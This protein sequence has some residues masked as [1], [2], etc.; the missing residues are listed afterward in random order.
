MNFVTLLDGPAALIVFG[1]TTLATLLRCGW[2]DC[3]AAVRAVG[4][5]GDTR[6]DA[7]G[8]RAEL[9]VQIQEI[10]R[11]GIL[12]AAPH[13]FGDREFDEVTGALIRRRSVGALLAA[14]EAHKARRQAHNDVPV[15]T[16]AQ[17]AELA[18]VFGLAGTLLALTQLPPSGVSSA[19]Y[20]ATISMAV[21][22]TLYG[23]LFSN[24][25]L[26]PL[27]RTLGRA[28]E[29]EETDRQ[30]VVDWLAR[31]VSADLAGARQ[32]PSG[33]AAA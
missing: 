9:A 6:F 8:V 1:G 31:Q 15:R 12:R 13:E 7:E 20:A 19:D 22:A 17:A 30:A 28:A 29:A 23:L 24:L 14:H 32:G 27:A 11:D 16:F 33:R 5:I 10:Q 25:V 21:L 2:H 18:P 26:A 4:T 3:V